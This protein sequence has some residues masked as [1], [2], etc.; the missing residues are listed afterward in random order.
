MVQ[1]VDDVVPAA[2]KIVVDAEDI[3]ALLQQP[4]AEM[5]AQKTGAPCDEYPLSHL[6]LLTPP[7]ATGALWYVDPS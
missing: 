5:G 7:H 1:K 2:G 3:V 4:L 6:S